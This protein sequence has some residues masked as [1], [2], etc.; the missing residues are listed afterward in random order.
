MCLPQRTPLKPFECI[1]SPCILPWWNRPYPKIW[2]PS[3][4]EL[5][6][7]TSEQMWRV[8]SVYASWRGEIIL[9]NSWLNSRLWLSSLQAE[10]FI[11]TNLTCLPPSIHISDN[12][13]DWL[14]SRGDSFSSNVWFGTKYSFWR[15]K[16]FMRQDGVWVCAGLCV[17][18]FHML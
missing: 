14:S 1:L 17:L 11:S 18:S 8:P 4:P 12:K 5:L 3:K 10:P 7:L 2:S 13:Q 15:I 16:L 6:K 9:L